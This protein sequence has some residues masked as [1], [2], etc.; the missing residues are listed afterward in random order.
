MDNPKR[1]NK[2]KN[3]IDSVSDR[4]GQL[5]SESGKNIRE[6]SAEIGVSMG[7]L[8]N[9][10]NASREIGITKLYKIAEYFKVS[11]DYLLGLS[12]TRTNDKGLAAVCEYTGL[13]EKVV[14][15]LENYNRANEKEKN[16]INYEYSL[17]LINHYI[18]KASY[19][20]GV[21]LEAFIPSLVKMEQL[22]K[23]F[24]RETADIQAISDIVEKAIKLSE[25]PL[26][27]PYTE[28]RDMI[29]FYFSQ[30]EKRQKRPLY[31]LINYILQYEGIEIN[32]V[33]KL[34]QSN[35]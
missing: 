28:A 14:P 17:A 35:I 11:A 22:D 27:E 24:H 23:K 25:H 10:Q 33:S 21:R 6:L 29:E 12:N 8:S 7:T 32:F 31:E 34:I 9:C 16:R 30:L 15:L 18:D 4:V 20:L 26:Y 19:D 2:V 5:I 1:K 3:A 13:S